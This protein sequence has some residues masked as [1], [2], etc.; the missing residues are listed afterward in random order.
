MKWFYP[1]FMDTMNSIQNKKF[2]RLAYLRKIKHI[3]S[4]LNE[5]EI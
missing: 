1:E 5:S 4:D 3:I 2:H